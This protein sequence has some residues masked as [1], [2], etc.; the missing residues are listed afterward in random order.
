MYL[1]TVAP[2]AKA[3]AKAKVNEKNAARRKLKLSGPQ[4]MRLLKT[5]DSFM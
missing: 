2:K 4:E 3:K 1:D 5:F